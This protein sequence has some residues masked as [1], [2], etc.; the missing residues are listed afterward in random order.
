VIHVS[1]AREGLSSRR[2]ARAATSSPA[3]GGVVARQSRPSEAP[4]DRAGD[5]RYEAVGAF[6]AAGRRAILGVARRFQR[7]GQ[8]QAV[9][10]HR[11]ENLFSRRAD[12]SSA[13]AAGSL[14]AR[15][16]FGGKSKW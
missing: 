11:R 14:S 10:E 15:I 12:S 8:A 13:A 2:R 1:S 5:E 7:S 16:G 3:R 9:V 4:R 6:A